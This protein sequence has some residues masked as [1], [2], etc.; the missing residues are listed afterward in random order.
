M[1]GPVY[2]CVVLPS[3][4]HTLCNHGIDG[5]HA[6]GHETTQKWRLFVQNQPHHAT[7]ASSAFERSNLVELVRQGDVIYVPAVPIARHLRV[8]VEE[9][10]HV[11]SL[12]S[13]EE[14]VRV[15]RSR[16]GQAHTCPA[17]ERFD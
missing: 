17:A 5:A 12:Q 16:R 2:L 14:K 8:N 15:R 4:K 10:G 9:N 7:H 11:N 3:A 1:Q 6:L 13:E